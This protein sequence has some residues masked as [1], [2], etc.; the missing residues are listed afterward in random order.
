[1]EIDTDRPAH[2]SPTR[3][4]PILARPQG[5]VSST[6]PDIALATTVPVT[7][8]ADNTTSESVS[9][10]VDSTTPHTEDTTPGKTVK[11]T[12]TNHIPATSSEIH[13]QLHK[14]A[15]LPTKERVPFH[16]HAMR[17]NRKRFYQRRPQ[18]S[19]WY[20]DF[21]KM[22]DEV[23]INAID[24]KL[25]FEL[26]VQLSQKLKGLDMPTYVTQ[27]ILDSNLI[28]VE[29]EDERAKMFLGYFF[30]KKHLGYN[31]VIRY[32]K[33]AK[34]FLFPR[35][36]IYPNP[37]IFNEFRPPQ[38]RAVDFMN[39]DRIIEYITKEKMNDITAYVILFA[40]Y[41]GLR[42]QEVLRLTTKHLD[43]LLRQ[44]TPIALHRKYNESWN[45]VYFPQFISF[46]STVHQFVEEAYV[47]YKENAVDTRLFPV[48]SSLVH[49]NLRKF[50]TIA[51]GHQPPMGFGL[52]SFRSYLAKKLFDQNDMPIAQH[53]LQHKNMKTTYGYVRGNEAQLEKAIN[54]V[55]EKDSM[56]QGILQTD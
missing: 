30:M 24:S 2:T 28:N 43:E 56:L 50:Y 8:I 14:M 31:S 45:V 1:M 11:V 33:S 54:N 32:F 21:M 22:K 47:Y 29:D 38:I 39:I 42:L 10:T 36:Q 26:Q 12:D 15:T 9:S 51:N 16:L 52:H 25:F 35:T 40:L 3:G 46:I 19:A 7:P 37:L 34:P 23:G 13:Q 55:N 17:R 53:L 20:R 48:S 6:T 4:S 27:F 5:N 49:H 41:T 18:E 44:Q